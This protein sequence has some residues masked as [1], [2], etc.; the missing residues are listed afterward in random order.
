MFLQG[1]HPLQIHLSPTHI[2]G[3]LHIQMDSVQILFFVLLDSFNIVFEEQV[4]WLLLILNLQL[5]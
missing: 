1:W 3:G 2:L 4:I 5:M